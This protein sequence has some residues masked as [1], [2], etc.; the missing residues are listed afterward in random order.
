MPHQLD[1]F[2]FRCPSCGE[3]FTVHVTTGVYAQRKPGPRA[4]A[5]VAQQ[6][7]QASHQRRQEEPRC[8]EHGRSA[9]SRW[10]G[11]YCPQQT[12]EGAYCRWRQKAA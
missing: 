1:A 12:A 7:E 2:G 9:R 5:R 3:G 10:G 8:P 4:A 6:A 11:W